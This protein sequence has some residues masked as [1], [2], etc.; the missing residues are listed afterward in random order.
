[1][2]KHEAADRAIEQAIREL[3]EAEMASLPD[4]RS[5]SPHEF[6]PQ[7]E[8]AMTSFMEALKKHKG[9]NTTPIWDE[10]SQRYI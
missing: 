5:A 2:S 1:M 6:S 9:S 3:H 4:P 7:F 8:A 10:E